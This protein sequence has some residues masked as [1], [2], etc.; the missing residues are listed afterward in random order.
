[1]KLAPAAAPT[2]V[3][4]TRGQLSVRVTED[5]QGGEDLAVFVCEVSSHH[6]NVKQIPR[7][8]QSIVELVDEYV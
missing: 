1:M 6:T 5:R 4:P 2:L 3:L 7:G 8:L